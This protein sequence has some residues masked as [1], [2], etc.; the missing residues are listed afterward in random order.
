MISHSKMLIV[1]NS[2]IECIAA[3][4][5]PDA[6]SKINC[7]NLGT[8]NTSQKMKAEQIVNRVK[9]TSDTRPDVICLC[10]KG[11]QHNHY[12]IV[13]SPRPFSLGSKDI[14]APGLNDSNRSFIP[15]TVMVD[16]LFETF[17]PVLI[18]ALYDAFPDAARV[19]LNAPPPIGSWDHIVAHPRF[20]ADRISYGPAPKALRLQLYEAQTEALRNISSLFDARFID[21]P[22]EC[23]DA[24]G[25][26]APDYWVVDPTHA[27]AA[28]GRSILGLLHEAAHDLS[29]KGSA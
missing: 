25:F 3:A 20:F 23:L 1:G 9:V 29:Q 17:D 27:N 4:L 24:D 11:N 10:I 26:L 19:L 7:V 18:G 5:L 2:H 16:H 28:Y 21:A 22:V 13:E 6:D 14:S 8:M 12:G 15:F